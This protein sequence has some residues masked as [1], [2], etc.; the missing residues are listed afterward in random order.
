MSES[1]SEIQSVSTTALNLA[2]LCQIPFA[3]VFQF[4][5]EMA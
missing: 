2:M 4:A 5:L 3:S 1:V